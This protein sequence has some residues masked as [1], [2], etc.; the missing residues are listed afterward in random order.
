MNL[1]SIVILVIIA[2][3]FFMGLRRILRNFLSKN[4]G[5]GC[6]SDDCCC[7]KDEGG[8]NRLKEAKDHKCPHCAKSE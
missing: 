3:L 4:A 6:G 5:C 1:I 8:H 7:F 2:L